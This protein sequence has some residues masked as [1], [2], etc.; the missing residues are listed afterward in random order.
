VNVLVLPIALWIAYGAIREA[1][2]QRSDT[3]EAHEAQ[4]A[5]QR[6]AAEEAAEAHRERMAEERRVAQEAAAAHARTL[7][8]EAKLQR[9][10]QT[11]RLAD[12]LVEIGDSARVGHTSRLPSLLIQLRCANA[13]LRAVGET[14]LSSMKILSES[15]AASMNPDQLVGATVDA[16][17]AVEWNARAE[18][19]TTPAF[20]H[21]T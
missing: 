10:A 3:R 8:A 2:G 16:L 5:E 21:G 12:L 6:R 19:N 13:V 14:G 4:M 1:R 18:E 11:Q 17:R 15:E 9:L 20:Q 7:A